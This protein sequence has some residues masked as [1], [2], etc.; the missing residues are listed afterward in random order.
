GYALQASS[1]VPALRK[2]VQ[3]GEQLYV[4]GGAAVNVPVPQVKEMGADVVIAVDVDERLKPVPLDTFR[5]VGSIA[6]RMLLLDLARGDEPL[7]KMAD[8]VIHP[9]VDKIRLVS[10][11]KEDA[12]RAI[13][14][15]EDAAVAALPE[16]K[17]RLQQQGIALRQ[18]AQ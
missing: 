4:D 10:T 16:I 13:K 2:P 17:A 11:K 5:K 8:V 3:I 15:G 1:A 14:A 18:R 7:D 9:Q 12:A 6:E